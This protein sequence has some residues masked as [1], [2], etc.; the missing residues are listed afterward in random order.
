MG[1]TDIM[2]AWVPNAPGKKS[3][4]HSSGFSLRPS[5]FLIMSAGLALLALVVFAF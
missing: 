3:V 2:L 4:R 5:D 1:S